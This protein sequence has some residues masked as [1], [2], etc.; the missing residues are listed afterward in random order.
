[1]FE[2]IYWGNR[3][4]IIKYQSS[5]VLVTKIIDAFVNEQYIGIGS[6]NDGLYLEN[7][8]SGDIIV[9]YRKV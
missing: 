3:Y 5:G 7:K 8:Y 6:D 9:K 1:M 2:I 4:G